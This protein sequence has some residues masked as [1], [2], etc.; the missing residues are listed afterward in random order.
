MAKVG[1]VLKFKD[2]GPSVEEAR[3][4]MLEANEAPSGMTHRPPV[5]VAAAVPVV[6]EVAEVLEPEFEE[7][8]VPPVAAAP[9]VA[10][11]AAPAPA[12]PPPPPEPR[13]EKIE[14]SK[15]IG[16]IKRENGK[17]VAELTYKTGA[18]QERWVKDTKDE[19]MLA[20]L[21]GKGHATLRVNKAVRREKL[22]WS[23]LD[24][25]YPL[26]ENI[27]ADEFAKM[28]DKQ[29]DATLWTIASQQ[30]LMFRDKHPEYYA[31]P[32]NASRI[33]EFIAKE[34]L[35]T[36]LRNLEYAFEELS[37]PNL[38]NDVRLEERLEPVS[39]TPVT[40]S[41]AT[42]E[43]APVRKDSVQAEPAPAA[44]TA[45]PA[46][47][48]PAVVVRKRGTTGL[49]PGQ[50]SSPE[51]ISPEDGGGQRELSEAELRAL[52]LGELKRI[53]TADRRKRAVSQR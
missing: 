7:E 30:I 19:L 4:K 52:P 41:L 27:S 33:N 53:A 46:V 26:P 3:R 45:A 31:T 36:T 38:P 34:K 35:P 39:I 49:Q 12:A 5:A 29:Q 10:P 44:P 1:D 8:I 47:A 15:F 43:P 14:T 2:T 17:W 51:P 9:A 28:T 23:E 25:Q 18:G 20:L 22:G 13:V 50:S 16:L 42:N 48:A 11:V 6:P 21:E 32:L 40:P 37:D 24:R